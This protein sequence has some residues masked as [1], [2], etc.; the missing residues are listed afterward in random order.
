[1]RF[2]ACWDGKG[3]R[4]LDFLDEAREELSRYKSVSV[5]GTRVTGI[6]PAGGRI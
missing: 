6:T 5:R 3:V 4:L 1:M 2:T